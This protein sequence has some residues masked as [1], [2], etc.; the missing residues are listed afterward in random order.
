MKKINLIIS[1]C[2]IVLGAFIPI[3]CS[4]DSIDNGPDNVTP[5]ERVDIQLSS[6][7]RA[8]ARS[9][10]DFYIGFTTDA[11]NFV[12]NDASFTSKNFS[13]SPL[14]ASMVLAMIANGTDQEV[15]TKIAGYLGTSD[16][17]ALNEL[18][19]IL[20][21]ELP[22]LDNQTELKLANSIW[23]NNQ[24]KLTDSFSS[25][26][27]KEYEAIISYNDF[28]GN[29]NKVI[30]DINKWCST[31]TAG[32]IPEF[33]KQLDP[34]TLAVF[35]NAVYFKG[36]W[37][38]GTFLEENTKKQIFNGSNGPAQVDMMHAYSANRL[39]A[40]DGN[41]KMFSLNFGNSA[42]NL[43]I[44]RPNEKLS[45]EEANSMLTP[46]TMNKLMQESVLCNL[47]VGIPKFKIE[48]EIR[49]NNIFASGN[50]PEVNRDLRL[51]MFDPAI[52]DGYITFLQGAAFQIDEKGVKAAAVTGGIVDIL[53]PLAGKSYSVT[54]DRPFYFFLN[55]TSTGACIISGRITDI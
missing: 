2:M 29:I 23:V 32:L 52:E 31:Q 14:S 19:E 27:N 42:F 50:L 41:F 33:I 38:E 54:V 49:L 55:E 9:L 22:K 47:S 45:L 46:E 16:I 36:L 30:K 13:V 11:A 5:N 18:A 4:S 21:T 28:K 39:Y 8:A 48:N 12:D 26:M 25:L 34:A 10:M 40:D 43:R 53:A 7:T 35:L 44:V 15:Q 3:A 51:D 20:L 6:E 1:S 24:F 17:N 37:K